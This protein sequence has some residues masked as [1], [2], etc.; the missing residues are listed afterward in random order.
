MAVRSND[1]QGHLGIQPNQKVVKLE[2]ELVGEYERLQTLPGAILVTSDQVFRNGSGIIAYDFTTELNDIDV[3]AYYD[4]QL[5]DNG[6][7]FQKDE[8]IKDQDFDRVAKYQ[9][10]ELIVEICYGYKEN[11]RRKIKF[12]LHVSKPV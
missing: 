11:N 10:G 7:T 12:S 2:A 4:K 1:K 8:A 3:L 6:W 5:K 9:K